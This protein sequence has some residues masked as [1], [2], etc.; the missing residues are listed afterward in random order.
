MGVFAYRLES[1][2]PASGEKVPKQFCIC[3]HSAGITPSPGGVANTGDMGVGSSVGAHSLAP[4]VAPNTQ[5]ASAPE[6]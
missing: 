6:S 4:V 1:R 5:L 2:A 3:L